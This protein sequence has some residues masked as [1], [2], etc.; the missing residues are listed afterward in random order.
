MN[1]EQHEAYWRGY[2]DAKKYEQSKPAREL[3]GLTD[4]EIHD[5]YD[6][7]ARREPY[8]MAVTRRNIARAIEAKLR[9][10]NA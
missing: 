9:E 7:V 1:Q 6:E 3:V 2:N 8:N 5:I 4:E 10:K